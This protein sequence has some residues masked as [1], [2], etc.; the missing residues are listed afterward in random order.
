VWRAEVLGGLTATATRSRSGAKGKRA[1]NRLTAASRRRPAPFWTLVV[2]YRGGTYVWQT[3]A[4]DPD[5]AMHQALP[6]RA[7]KVTPA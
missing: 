6:R 4:A 5:E 1:S 7:P 2:D 3:R